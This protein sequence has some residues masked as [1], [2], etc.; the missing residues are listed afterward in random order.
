[1]N[2]KSSGFVREGKYIKTDFTKVRVIQEQDTFKIDCVDFNFARTDGGSLV[3][4]GSN[5][6]VWTF[7]DISAYAHA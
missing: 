7:Y 6:S 2:N 4:I 5:G 1:M 3:V